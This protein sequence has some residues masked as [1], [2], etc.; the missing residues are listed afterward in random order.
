MTYRERFLSNIR[1]DIFYGVTAGVVAL[2]RA[3]GFGVASGFEN[4]AA[5][6]IYG[7][8]A[9]GICA[10][11]FGGTPAQISGP[12]GPMTVA[13]ARIASSPKFRPRSSVL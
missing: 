7:A 1:G 6:G 9:V 10:A 4:G 5:I 8:I 12:T 2:P 11:V 13:V 3:L